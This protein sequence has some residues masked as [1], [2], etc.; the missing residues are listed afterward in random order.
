MILN[1]QLGV[2]L[3]FVH[4]R[5]KKYLTAFFQE[6]GYN[7]TPEQF[8]LL[9]ALWDMGVMPQQKIADTMLK[10]KNSV[11]K[12]VDALEKKG[13]VRRG[14]SSHDRRQNLIEVTPR[15]LEI[16]DGVTAAAIKAVDLITKDISREDLHIFLNVLFNMS[17]NMNGDVN[18]LK[19]DNTKDYGKI[20]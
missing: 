12:L 16:K 9:D 19:T 4:N 8:L 10:D 5:F 3:N 11:V 2:F 6:S 20:I 17:E 1:K 18:L 13:L 14:V 15:G 7:I